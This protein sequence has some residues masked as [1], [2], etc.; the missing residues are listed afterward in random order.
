MCEFCKNKDN[1]YN[2][3]KYIGFDLD[4]D[5]CPVCGNHLS[6]PNFLNYLEELINR[7]PIELAKTEDETLIVDREST[8]D[9][10][11]DLCKLDWENTNIDKE[12]GWLKGEQ[13]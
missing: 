8:A 13:R 5:Y 7:P 1:I 10:D 2:L 12:L 6:I 11:V 4:C 9:Y 3:Q